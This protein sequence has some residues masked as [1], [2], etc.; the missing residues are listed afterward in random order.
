MVGA[1]LASTVMLMNTV[2]L[3]DTCDVKIERATLAITL[4]LECAVLAM[5]AR[6]T[7]ASGGPDKTVITTS[8]PPP[9]QRW[10]LVSAVIALIAIATRAIVDP[11]S[12]FDT[13]FRWDSVA[14]QVFQGGNLEFY[15]PVTEADFLKYPWCD[16]IAPLISSL[17]LWCYTSLGHIAA[18]ATAPV[19]IIQAALLF[20]S[21][22]MLAAERAGAAAGCL[23]VAILATSS[24]LLWGVAMGQE[25]AMTALALVAMLLFI[26]RHRAQPHE[27]WLFWAGIAAGCGA[28]AREYGLVFI[29]L[30]A[31]TLVWQR[32]S[33]RRLLEFAL[34]ACA[35]AAPWYLRNWIKTGNP[36]YSYNLASLFP[37][38]Q[39]HD[40][41]FRTIHE[42]HSIGVG[43][44]CSQLLIAMSGWAGVSL[45]L[46]VA[47]S[48]CNWRKCAPWTLAM[49][50]I[51][52]LWLWSIGQTAGGWT[53]SMR[54]L[55]P[56]IAVSSVLG[57]VML[58]RWVSA[59]W[60]LGC[61]AVFALIA[62][63]AGPRSLYLPTKTAVAWWKERALAWREFNEIGRRWQAYQCWINIADAAQHRSVIVT[64]V[65]AHTILSG[66]GTKAVP[67]FSP[68]IG[69]LFE[70]SADLGSCIN[71]LRHRDVRF[72]LFSQMN[73]LNDAFFSKY[74]FWRALR[75]IK[76]S[77]EMCGYDVYDL[78][79]PP[80]L[81]PP[82]Q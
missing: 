7:K 49:L 25:T 56:A 58:A 32:T 75:Q 8:W 47:A 26:E 24:M 6:R 45:T 55:T 38:N 54:V 79:G 73:A 5:L 78:W 37:V 30:G 46:G 35:I 82:R 44:S 51:V 66:K 43:V 80:L 39:I 22:Y 42:F 36:L 9:P 70:P 52:T 40:E 1:F 59:R 21:V 34:V 50:V 16:G 19:V 74:P 65:V 18:W 2:L 81:P 76:P 17:Y 31:F 10:L 72:V 3:L 20:W 57:G 4:A 77:A 23:A 68:A 41:C 14:R 12:G 53:Y 67:I 64:D 11:L 63:D 48:V 15:P 62:A 28:L 33:W 71:R 29:A 27:R 13:S 69:F 60:T 61:A